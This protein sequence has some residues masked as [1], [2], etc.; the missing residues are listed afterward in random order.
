MCGII[1]IF[2]C[3]DDK[4]IEEDFTKAF[5]SISH[6]GPDSKLIYRDD[7]HIY[8]FHRLS[9]IDTSENS[10]Q[11]LKD[12]KGRVVLCNG[13]IFNYK[14][15]IEEY[16][17][18]TF[19]VLSDCGILL[20]LY[21]KV[22]FHKMIELLIGDF[23]IVLTD[24]NNV[25]LGRD[26]IG[27]RPLFYGITDKDLYLTVA[28]EA[29]ALEFLCKEIKQMEFTSLVFNL[30]GDDI[31]RKFVFK[32]EPNF[33]LTENE[34]CTSLKDILFN[35]VK[36]RLISHRP[37]G[38]LLSG[39][40]DSSLI[41]SILCKLLGPENV[42]TYSIGM[43][44][45]PDLKNARLV[46]EFLKTQHTEVIMTPEQGLNAIERVIK[47]IESYDITTIRA[48]IPMMLLGEY[49]KENT[50][51]K[52]IFSG[53]GADELFCG[54]LYFHHS[55]SLNELNDESAR[56]INNLRYY[57]VLRADR[58]ISSSGLELRVPFLD[59]EVIDFCSK[60][61]PQ[62]KCPKY[63]N[64]NGKN[65]EKY[66]LRKSFEDNFLP[67]EVLF[68][69]KDGLSDGCSSHEKSWYMY[70]Q[71]YITNIDTFVYDN[72]KFPSKEA[73]YYKYIYN[74][75]YKSYNPNISYWMPKWVE[76]NDPS[77]RLIT[78]K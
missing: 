34:I 54:Y 3:G 71:E 19:G 53:E 75:Y 24:G 62:F 28:S 1:S 12:D 55:P 5:D 21:D 31:Y 48:S 70:I 13:E 16:K 7:N 36:R 74:K 32:N 15:L 65:C 47:M 22:G 57:D 63:K 67:N 29:K 38:V 60:I 39:G 77:G 64:I 45:S 44:G 58:C 43:K 14:E 51:D 49:I 4:S 17:L 20:D 50:E 78:T 30:E 33:S 73:Q 46:S 35:S 37:I 40:L 52:V 11:P 66:I 26:R 69:T 9:I 23:A 61:P 76:S 6:R 41:T 68:R 56:I 10:M 72:T 25:Y 18:N 59:P 42:R 2:N 8:G 27:V